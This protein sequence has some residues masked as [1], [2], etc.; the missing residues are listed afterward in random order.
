MYHLLDAECLHKL[1]GMLLHWRLVSSPIYLLMQLFTSIWTHRYLSYSIG[2]NLT[3][4]AQPVPAWVIGSSSRWL[5]CPR[6]SFSPPITT[7]VSAGGSLAVGSLP[8]AIVFCEQQ[9]S[10][11]D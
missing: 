6:V 11:D 2:C 4:L 10:S 1:F 7:R 5:L 3:R 8:E 9:E